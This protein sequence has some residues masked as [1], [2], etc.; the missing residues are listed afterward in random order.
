MKKILLA[1]VL[2]VLLSTSQTFAQTN[3][4]RNAIGVAAMWNDYSAPIKDSFYFDFGPQKTYGQEFWYGRYLSPSFNL[5]VPLSISNITYPNGAIVGQQPTGGYTNSVAAT[6]DAQLHYKFN[7]GYILKENSFIAPYVYF[8]V[9][10]VGGMWDNALPKGYDIY[11]PFGAGLKFQIPEGVNL[12][13]EAGYR[14]TITLDKHNF[15]L[16]AG[17]EMPFGKAKDRDGDGVS[18][19]DDACPDVPGLAALKGCP[20]KDGDGVADKDDACPDVAGLASLKG[21]PDKD[22]DGIT[23]AEDTCPDVAGLAALKGCPDKDGD[24]IADGDDACPDVA[25]LATLKGC[26]DSD[27]DGIA[28]KDDK[29]PSVKGTAAMMGCPDRDGDGVADA[30]DACP[31]VA[32]SMALK[33]C[34]DSDGDGIADKDDKCPKEKGTPARQGCPEPAAPVVVAKDSDGDGVVDSQDKCPTE[35]GSRDNFG[36]PIK[37]A[38]VFSFDNI[39]FE[40]GKSVI[41]TESYATL[42]EVVAIMRDNPNH[43]AAIEGHTDSQGNAAANQK[44]SEARAKACLDYLVTKGIAKTRLSSFGFGDKVPVADNKTAEGRAKN[45]RVEFKL[46]LP[47]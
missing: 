24:G 15:L 46:S 22:G 12:I 8:G 7:N 30:D 42:D 37:K 2:L 28:D 43:L 3:D 44:L 31:D 18:D 38:V 10:A 26:P 39:L 4:A 35:A 9:A 45:R 21:C 41:K 11:L 5:K 47:K 14:R 23:D 20:D 34:P 36:C 1:I 6:L 27:G 32:G 40:T 13:A 16:K 19:K 33:G 29:C 17:I 25:G